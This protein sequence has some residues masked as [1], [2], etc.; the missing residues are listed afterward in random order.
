VA[1]AST[2]STGDFAGAL[3]KLSDLQNA[4]RSATS[5]GTVSASRSVQIQAAI[6]LVRE[7]LQANLVPVPTVAPT[8]SPSVAPNQVGTVAPQ[9]PPDKGDKGGKGGHGKN[10]VG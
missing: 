4:L 3:G 10:R 6:D 7:D 8:P 9:N 1:V 2:S 5:A